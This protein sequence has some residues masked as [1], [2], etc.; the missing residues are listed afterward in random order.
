MRKTV[1]ALVFSLV[2]LA[3]MAL[4]VNYE[5]AGNVAVNFWNAHRDS[6]V[7]AISSMRQI[8]IPFDGMYVFAAPTTGFVIVAADDCVQP[9]LAYSFTSP[10]STQLNPE[11]SYWLSTY[12]EQI[13]FLRSIDAVGSEEVAAQW[14]EY[15][16]AP[17]GDPVP[18]TM[19]PPLISTTWDQSPYYNKFCPY[20]SSA[21]ARTVAGCVATA[22]AQVMKY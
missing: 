17:A 14:Q 21:H 2:G 1:F 13:D 20:D 15:S 11:V 16:K 22:T 10:A 9:I 5:T 8:D 7:A 19:V 12:Q 3:A 4:P 6:D 18:L